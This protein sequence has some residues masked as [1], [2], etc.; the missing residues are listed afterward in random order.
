MSFWSDFV[1]FLLAGAIILLLCAGVIGFVALLSIPFLNSGSSTDIAYGV[2]KNSYWS[3]LYLRDD[4]KTAYCI[5]NP[6]LIA[7]AEKASVEKQKVKVS[8]QEYVFR[9]SLCFVGEKYS[10]VVV[11]NIE[12]IE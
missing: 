10:S 6:D 12:V 3:K 2:E 1:E 5:D 9:G 7:I 8:Y 11:T 4:H